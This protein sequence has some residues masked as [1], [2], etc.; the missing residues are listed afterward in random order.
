MNIKVFKL[1]NAEEIL[2]EVVSETPTQV[3]I[4]N[5]LLVVLQRTPQGEVGVGFLP[6]MGY[7]E[8]KEFTLSKDHII[9]DKGVDGTLKNQYN[10]VFG[11]I[12]TPTKKLILT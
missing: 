1:V 9:F 10:A 6:Y 3:Q 7:V 5:P 2:G 8:N 4:K 11:N 12:V